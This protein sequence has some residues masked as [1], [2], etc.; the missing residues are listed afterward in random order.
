MP[1][2]FDAPLTAYL[3]LVYSFIKIGACYQE[4]ST[5]ELNFCYQYSRHS[6]YI[7]YYSNCTLWTHTQWNYTRIAI[8]ISKQRISMD[9][10]LVVAELWTPPVP[11][12]A[13]KESHAVASNSTSY[14]II[15]MLK[16]NLLLSTC[17]PIFQTVKT[18]LSNSSYPHSLCKPQLAC[19]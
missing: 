17:E 3:L 15:A 14:A 18:Q 7:K 5:L 11:P 1:I 4:L 8:S 19:T 10:L 9:F 6:A 2:Y 16:K 12:S 13:Q